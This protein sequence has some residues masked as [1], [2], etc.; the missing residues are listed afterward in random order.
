MVKKIIFVLL[1]II[2]S[3]NSA[4]CANGVSVSVDTIFVPL[5]KKENNDNRQIT[6]IYGVR[7]FSELHEN[8]RISYGFSGTVL[9]GFLVS[10]PVSVA[11]VPAITN[12]KVNL[13]PQV[14]AGVEPFYSNFPD[15]NGLKWYGHIGLGLDYIFDN[16]WFIN[17]GSKFYINESFFQKDVINKAFN[18]GVVELYGGGG[19]K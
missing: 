16:K 4:Y 18:T 3:H 6:I 9:N 7:G 1:F 11:Y 19:F 17:V 8:W 5:G 13:R 15:F 12:Y 14:F 2:F 10:I